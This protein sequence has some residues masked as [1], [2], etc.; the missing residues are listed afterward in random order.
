[1]T[2]ADTMHIATNDGTR[3]YGAII[4]YCHITY[5]HGGII[6]INALAK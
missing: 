4:T 3:P 6:D 1:M 5:N 2:N